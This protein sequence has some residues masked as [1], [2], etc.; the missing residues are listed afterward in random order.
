[1]RAE[2]AVSGSRTRAARR[3]LRLPA[4]LS[5][6]GMLLGAGMLLA[7]LAG[8]PGTPRGQAPPGAAHP[9]TAPE[10]E[11]KPEQEPAAAPRTCR[12]LTWEW[13]TI[14]RK[15]VNHRW[16]KK[17]YSAL[18]PEER[19]A[20]SPCTVCMADQTLLRLEGVP[21]F[22]VCRHVADK[23][24]SALEEIIAAGFPVHTIIGYRVGRT[25]GGPD[26][27]GLRTR[28]SNHSYG[29]AIDINAERNGMYS[30]CVRFGPGCR[31]IRGG[32][33]RPTAPGTITAGSIVVAAFRAMGWKWGGAIAGTQKD[34]MHFSFTGY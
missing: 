14:T 29:T 32:R 34:F 20:D 25:R 13:N 27:N 4:C 28:F 15:S 24:R 10:P 7:A 2:T 16:V 23:V 21:P 12:Y 11:Q 22:R 1:M 5:A 8:L 6:A 26:A 18:T 33:W 31:L 17:P 30:N 3:A 19:D 9:E